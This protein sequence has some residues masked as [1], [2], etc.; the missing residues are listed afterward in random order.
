VVLC[1]PQILEMLPPLETDLTNPLTIDLIMPDGHPKVGTMAGDLDLTSEGVSV[2]VQ[3]ELEV[4]CT[5][6][7]LLGREWLST[8]HMLEV[9]NIWG[10]PHQGGGHSCPHQT[11]H[12]L[13][14][15]DWKSQDHT[16]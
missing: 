14:S 8:L 6:L 7:Q 15:W 5:R 12:A 9:Y 1:L 2:W 11:G 4:I 10:E 13:Q 3:L 16:K